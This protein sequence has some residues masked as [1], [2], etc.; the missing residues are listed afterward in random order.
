MKQIKLIHA[1]VLINSADMRSASTLKINIWLEM[2]M[3]MKKE[4]SICSLV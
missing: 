2:Q 4:V 3:M 1:G